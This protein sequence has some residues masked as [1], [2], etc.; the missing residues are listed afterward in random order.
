VVL[1]ENTPKRGA[2]HVLGAAGDWWDQTA[3]A[4]DSTLGVSLLGGT[5]PDEQTLAVGQDAHDRLRSGHLPAIFTDAFTREESVLWEVFGRRSAATGRGRR[6][7]RRWHQGLAYG[8]G[9]QSDKGGRGNGVAGRAVHGTAHLAPVR[10]LLGYQQINTRVVERHNG[11]SRLRNQ[12]KVRKTLAVSTAR[13][14]HGWRRWRSVGL[15]HFCRPHRRLTLNKADQVTHRRPA[16]A[17]GVTDYLWSTRA[18]L[19]RPVLGGAEIIAGHY[20]VEN[21]VMII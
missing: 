14:Y 15:S 20:L 4:V 3:V 21:G 17:A 8:Q 9:Q 18:W 10:Y 5:R 6:P 12:R 16:M 19:L 1:G 2:D 13:R 11:P 7:G